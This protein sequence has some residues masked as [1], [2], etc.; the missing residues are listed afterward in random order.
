MDGQVL[1]GGVIV[2]V[3]VALWLVYLLPSLH[4][5]HRYDSAQRHA[6][7]LNQALR[8]LAE[9]SE[10]PDAVQIELNARSAAAQQKLARKAQDERA[11]VELEQAQAELAAARADAARARAEAARLREQAL[12]DAA[13]A[14]A[15]PAVRRARSRRRARL[16][17]TLLAAL[18]LGAAAWGTVL[19]I[20]TGTFTVLTVGVILTLV[21]GVALSRMSR[22]Q[23]RAAKPI[24]VVPRERVALPMQDVALASDRTAWTPR[25]LPR[26]LT[27][28][29]GSRAAAVLDGAAARESLRHAARDETLRERVARHRPPSIDERRRQRAEAELP[30]V[31]AHDD[32]AIEAH[33][34]QLLQRRA[35]GAS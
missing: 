29:A 12:A 18:G 13:R 26:P 31:G 3:A 35:V 7:R 15:D 19:L 2:L 5:R 23:R 34:R 17:A 28:S 6:V 22:V 16:V 9:T 25:E 21:A 14:D 30:R 20:S 24:V 10:T 4:G 27:A 32:D 33:V 8:V 11:K 1:G